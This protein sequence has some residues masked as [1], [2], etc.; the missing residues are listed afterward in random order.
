MWDGMRD[1][2]CWILGRSISIALCGAQYPVPDL[3]VFAAEASMPQS[4]W[5]ITS[6][7]TVPVRLTSQ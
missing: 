3:S 2:G 6:E 1:A 4:V 5:G 7:T